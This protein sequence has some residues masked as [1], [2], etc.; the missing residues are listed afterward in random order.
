MSEKNNISLESDIIA[1]HLLDSLSWQVSTL[2]AEVMQD[3]PQMST[4]YTTGVFYFILMYMG[5]NVLPIGHFL[6][7]SHMQ[8]SFR[9]EEVRWRLVEEFINYVLYNIPCK[10]C[11]L[12]KIYEN[13]DLKGVQMMWIEDLNLHK[14]MWRMNTVMVCLLKCLNE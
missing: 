10:I 1:R 12:M 9:A 7:M 5:S 13:L 11:T 8:Q 6:H 4:L 2:L 14:K 3:N